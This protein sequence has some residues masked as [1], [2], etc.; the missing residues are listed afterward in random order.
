MDLLALTRGRLVRFGLKAPAKERAIEALLDFLVAE[1]AVPRDAREQILQAIFTRERRLSTGLEDGVAI[2][3]G[4]TNAIEEEV[5]AVGIFPE[6]VPFDAADG[7][8]ARIVILLITPELKRYRHVANLASIARQMRRRELRELLCQAKALPD[9]IKA[10]EMP[11]P[12]GDN[13][14]DD[15]V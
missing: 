1:Q 13:E 11:C 2:P 6:G 14:G 8:P 5:A 4:I 7:L 15:R 12:E 3:H 9:A 10:L